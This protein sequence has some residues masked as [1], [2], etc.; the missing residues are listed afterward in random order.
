MKTHFHAPRELVEHPDMLFNA[1][2]HHGIALRSQDGFR[3]RGSLGDI[4]FYVQIRPKR[5]RANLIV[6]ITDWPRR[7]VRPATVDES[8]VKTYLSALQTERVIRSSFEARMAEMLSGRGINVVDD[9]MAAEID[10]I[11]RQYPCQAK[12]SDSLKA[13]HEQQQL[14]KSAVDAE[15]F[16][17]AVGHV[18]K[19]ERLLDTLYD[20][21][22][23]ITDSC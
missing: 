20:F 18:D 13:I 23:L 5:F 1:R 19:R 9:P 12:I 10:F 22:I 17:L 2:R 21:C 16:D 14:I 11:I 8:S 3:A 4:D 6:M 7:A 15:D